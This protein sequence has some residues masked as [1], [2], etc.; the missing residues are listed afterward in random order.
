MVTVIERELV[1]RKCSKQNQHCAKDCLFLP[2]KRKDEQR[3]EHASRG[4]GRQ[5]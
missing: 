3:A 2:G 1:F 4:Q 5:S